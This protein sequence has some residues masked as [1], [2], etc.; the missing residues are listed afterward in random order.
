MQKMDQSTRMAPQTSLF[1]VYLRLRPPTECIPMRE[2]SEQW[3]I[4]EPPVQAATTEESPAIPSIS[5]HVTLQ[6]PNDS[7]KRAIERF[8]F[9]KIFK[10]NA[11]QLDV[12]EETGAINAVRS[13]IQE[14]RDGLLAPLGVTGSGKVGVFAER[15]HRLQAYSIL[16]SHYP[17]LSKSTGTDT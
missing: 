15:D 10:E 14:R 17:R 12:F 7:R 8:N 11:T 6:P 1:Q 9:T 16:E 13:L 3:L 4:L 5:T 2:Q